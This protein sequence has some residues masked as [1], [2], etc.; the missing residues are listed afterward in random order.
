MT[1][2][3]DFALAV[4]IPSH[5]RKD[6]TLSCIRNLNAGQLSLNIFISDSG[7][8]DGTPEA[9]VLEPNVRMLKAGESAWWSEAINLGIRTALDEKFSS[10]LLLNDDIEFEQDLV[11]QLLNKHRQHPNSIISPLQQNSSGTFLGIR[12]TGPFNKMERLSSAESD[13]IVDT[14]NGCC[15]LV[16]R[17]VFESVGLMDERKC[18]HLA[19]DTEFQIRAKRAGFLT[20]ACPSIKI[21]QLGTTNY[22]VR[23]KIGSIF[24]YKGS[25]LHFA[26]HLQFGKSLFGTG[27]RFFFLGLGYHYGYCKTFIKALHHVARRLF[28]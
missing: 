11:L 20:L 25:P 5:N 10:I 18:P 19:G 23:L 9:V 1:R 28:Q 8:T 4:V 22:Y 6:V 12:Y 17:T 3:I 13:S 21:S 14:T 15:L 16:P 7:S 24:T 26:T 27:I 2:N